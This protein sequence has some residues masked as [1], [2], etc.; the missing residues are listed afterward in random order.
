MS[1]VAI[2]LIV[3]ACIFGA[4]LLGLLLRPILPERH[5]SADSKDTVRL[6]M[7]M[8][9]TMAALVLGL[10]VASAKNFY[11]TQSSELT[12]LSANAVLLDRVLAHY[13]PETKETRDSLRGAVARALDLI[14]HQDHQEHSQMAPTMG[15]G[16]I[17]YDKIQALSPTTDVQ[18]ALRA[19]ASSMAVDMGKLRWLMFEQGTTGISI[20]LLVVLVFWL[21]IVF[22]SFGL[23][24]PPNATVIATLFLCALSVSG[25]IWLILE[26]YTPFQG[27][28][29][30]SSAPLREALAHLGQ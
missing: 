16:E 17:V 26:M 30:I 9:A 3:L 8:I 6:G 4:A 11:D 14:R 7:G 24:A 27:V 5:L 2:R 18:R 23:F 19:Q 22:T 29:Q 13:G 10:L 21:T 1:Y 28:L 20:P 12:Q 15:G 25:A